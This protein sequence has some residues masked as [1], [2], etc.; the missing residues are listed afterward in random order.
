MARK[1]AEM[2]MLR[3]EVPESEGYRKIMYQWKKDI[4]E[5]TVRDRHYMSIVFTWQL[6][7]AREKAKL[8]KKKVIVGGPAVMLMPDYLSDVAKIEE[9]T[10]YPVLSYHNPMATF[11]T[12]GC[13]NGCS[14]CAVPK[15][16]GKTKRVKNFIP[17]PLICDNNIF[18]ESLMWF[19]YV[20]DQVKHFPVVDF[21]QGVEAD[22]FTVDHARMISEIKYPKLRFSFDHI[23]KESAVMDAISLA[24]NHGIKDVGCYVLFGHNDDLENALYRL[25]LLRSVDVLPNPMRYQPL[26]TLVKNS[27]VDKNWREID[28]KRVSRYYSK[29]NFLGGVPFSDYTYH[30]EGKRKQEVMD[31]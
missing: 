8:S 2:S 24:R 7:L 12:R 25:E 3:P 16:E 22:L 15:I 11:T 14:F 10:I 13:N 30:D 19:R 29:L 1:A 4:V 18:Q 21:N 17:S 28:L 23:N 5:W 26:D 20:I 31:F 27:H 6:P 9:S